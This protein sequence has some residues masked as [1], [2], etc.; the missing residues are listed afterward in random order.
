[1]RATP[2]CRALFDLDA[3]E[4]TLAAFVSGANDYYLALGFDRAFAAGLFLADLER[5][6]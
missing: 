2:A 1:M 4:R 5:I 6:A 3:I